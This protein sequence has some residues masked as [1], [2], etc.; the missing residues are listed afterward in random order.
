MSGDYVKHDNLV[1]I[2]SDGKVECMDVYGVNVCVGDFVQVYPRT[3][4]LSMVQGIVKKITSSSIVLENEDNE[5]A[6]RY[7]E[8]KMVRKPKTYVKQ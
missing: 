2:Y 1:K 6:I 3:M 5:V 8:L 7:S 4:R